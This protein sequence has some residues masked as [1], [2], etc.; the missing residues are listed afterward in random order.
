MGGDERKEL[1]KKRPLTVL[2]GAVKLIYRDNANQ[3]HRPGSL[4]RLVLEFPL[5][6]QFHNPASPLPLK[7]SFF[8]RSL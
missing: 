8:A 7:K 4:S 5:G 3:E 6:E 2:R 1:I